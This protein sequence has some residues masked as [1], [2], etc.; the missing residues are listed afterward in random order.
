MQFRTELT[1]PKANFLLSHQDEVLSIG[2]CFADTIAQKLAFFKFKVTANSFGTIFNPL[3]ISSL[4]DMA[5]ADEEV[6]W[7]TVFVNNQW[8]SLKVHSSIYAASE[9]ELIAIL[10][11][12][13]SIFRDKL[14]NANCLIITLGTAWV[15]QYLPLQTTVANCHKIPNTHFDKI[16][17]SVNEIVSSLKCSL[18]KLRKLNTLLKVILT[19]SPVRHLKDTLVLNTVS[20]S[21]LQLAVYELINA[22]DNVF[23]F[24][25]Y[26]LLVDDLRDYRFYGNDLIH[27]SEMAE[28]YIFEKFCAWCMDKETLEINQKI[29]KIQKSLSHRPIQTQGEVYEK[30]VDNIQKMIGELPVGVWS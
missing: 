19:V 20:K 28:N 17:L 23:Y 27:P 10:D 16:L 4:I 13:Q 6:N 21:T 14:L 15:Y 2:S 24:P 22:I 18:E 9:D 26:E 3:S 8:V 29:E 30:H 25:A 1:L 5:C 7:Q 11:H 12:K